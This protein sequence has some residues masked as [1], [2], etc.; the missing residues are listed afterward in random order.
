MYFEAGT[1]Y[2]VFR[3]GQDRTF[4]LG[5]HILR[6]SRVGSWMEIFLNQLRCPN[7]TNEDLLLAAPAYAEVISQLIE[8]QRSLGRSTELGGEEAI[9]KFFELKKAG[10]LYAL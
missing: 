2:F 1:I 8:E 10:T 5:G 6:W 9:T 3:N 4:M 7:S